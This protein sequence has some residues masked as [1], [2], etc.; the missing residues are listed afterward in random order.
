MSKVRKAGTWRTTRASREVKGAIIGGYLRVLDGYPKLRR[1]GVPLFFVGT[2]AK[3]TVQEGPPLRLR[4]F[5]QPLPHPGQKVI[6]RRHLL[7]QVREPLIEPGNQRL[8]IDRR[9]PLRLS[10][11]LP[12]AASR[13]TWSTHPANVMH[14]LLAAFVAAVRVSGETP[15]NVHCGRSSFRAFARDT[16]GVRTI[17]HR[18]FPGQEGHHNTP[19]AHNNSR[20]TSGADMKPLYWRPT[21]MF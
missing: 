6:A 4:Q 5:V 3:N 2:P 17:F 18:P 14:A 8:D 10:G 7:S 9:R 15:F 21:Q 16:F 1:F 13:S 11:K 19:R 20:G 12:V